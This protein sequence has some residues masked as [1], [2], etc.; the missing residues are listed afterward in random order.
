MKLFIDCEFNEFGGDLIS[1]ALV[2]ED[3]QEFYEVLNLETQTEYGPWVAENVVPILNKDP[4]SKNEFQFKLMMFLNQYESIRVIADWPDDI[5]YFC[6]SLI[7]SPGQCIVTPDSFTIEIDRS[8]TTVESKLPHNALEDA[9][10][11]MN[12]HN[13]SKGDNPMSSK[14]HGELEVCRRCGTSFRYTCSQCEQD[15]SKAFGVNQSRPTAHQSKRDQTD[16]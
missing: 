4:I 15:M 6:M 3:C 7:T 8:L 13:F 1:M 2:A 14:T 5:K 16:E 10:A 9:R 12:S 11:I